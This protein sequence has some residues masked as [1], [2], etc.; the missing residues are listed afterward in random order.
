MILPLSQ[1]NIL[2]FFRVQYFLWLVGSHILYL[3]NMDYKFPELSNCSCPGQE[4]T[5]LRD[6]QRRIF[7]PMPKISQ[8]VVVV[9]II[10]IVGELLWITRYPSFLLIAVNRGKL[11]TNNTEDFRIHVKSFKVRAWCSELVITLDFLWANLPWC[12]W[13]HYFPVH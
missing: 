13:R 2:P 7:A 5:P 4:T 8:K 9:S 10:Q 3:W 1:V 12:L 11:K 6:V